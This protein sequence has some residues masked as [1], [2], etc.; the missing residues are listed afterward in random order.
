MDWP[1]P[2]LPIVAIAYK[3]PA[4][5]DTTKDTA[6]LDALAYLAFSNT[7]DLYQKLVVQEQKADAIFGG[8]PDNVDP[9]L[10]QIHGAGEEGRGR[11]LCAR[12]RF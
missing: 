3:G 2:T 7:S 11:G 12:R 5:S 4:Y 6:A 8:A 1:S 9:G 10:F